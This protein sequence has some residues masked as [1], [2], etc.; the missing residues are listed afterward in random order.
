MK[1]KIGTLIMAATMLVA[2]GAMADFLID[3]ISSYGIAEEDGFSPILAIGDT[4]IVQLY[5]AGI[6]GTPDFHSVGPGGEL[7]IEPGPPTGDDI[8][9]WEGSFLNTAD[10]GAGYA[11]GIYGL[12]IPVYDY[13]GIVP[14]FGRLWV[15][16]KLGTG[17]L[18]GYQGHVQMM[19]DSGGPPFPPEVYDLGEG[20]PD[21]V[22]N[23][24][25]IPEPATFGLIGLF[26]GGLYFVR[27]FFPSI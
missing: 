24:Y 23:V 19:G 12:G 1:A 18:C 14:I 4:A 10:P 8:L 11:A 7:Y 22:L 20:S 21:A 3:Y 26:S 17:E 27:R 15:A 6:N 9:L 2:G 13:D 25:C 16:D 5:H